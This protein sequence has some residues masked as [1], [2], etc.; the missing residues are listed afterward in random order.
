MSAQNGPSAKFS[1]LSTTFSDQDS[2]YL[3]TPPD[4]LIVVFDLDPYAW[5]GKEGRDVGLEALQRAAEDV[6]IFLNAHTALRHDNA[7]A[8]YAAGRSRGSLVFSNAPSASQPAIESS[9]PDANTYQPFKTISDAVLNG[10]RT[11][12]LEAKDELSSLPSQGVVSALSQALCHINR[13]NLSTSN[14]GGEEDRKTASTRAFQSRVLILTASPDS[15]SQYVSIMNCIF[16]AQK[17]GVLVD[18][19]K[20]F[21]GSDSVFLQQASHLTGG[22]YF[23]LEAVT[24][25]LQTLMTAFLASP[26][27]RSRIRL[28][29]NDDVDFRAACFC[30]GTVVDVGYV[31][32]VC[33]SIFCDPIE[34]CHTCRA[35]FPKRTLL[36]FQDEIKALKV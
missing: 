9:L 1:H 5:A 15:S 17:K 22:I 31:C 32:S 23:R 36:R 11:H 14:G 28:P 3:R 18:V 16:G 2:S 26:S 21:G 6:C 10:F 35:V 4:F 12:L 8:V 29:A 13:L 7:C 27:I 25:L 24:G 19:C 34:R 30:H 20:L 33:L